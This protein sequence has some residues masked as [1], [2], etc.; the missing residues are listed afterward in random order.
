MSNSMMI[1][2]E[3]LSTQRDARVLQAGWCIYDYSAPDFSFPVLGEMNVDSDS[4]VGGHVSD[5][6]V[7]WWLQGI[8]Q[9]RESV[10]REGL[11]IAL[12]LADLFHQYRQYKCTEVWSNGATFDIVIVEHWAEVCGMRVPWKFYDHRDT[13]TLWKIAEQLGWERKRGE[14]AHTAKADA[15]AQSIQVYE[16][17]KFLRG[18]RPKELDKG[19]PA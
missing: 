9:A 7:K 1:D 17:M 8:E 4:C 15:L 18:L 14:T 11:S 13:R 19:P 16:A 5:S 6:T 10:A 2:L 12:V 3:T